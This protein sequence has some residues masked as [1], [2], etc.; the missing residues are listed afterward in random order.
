MSK[1]NCI[2][3]Q[4]QNLC[5]CLFYI[6]TVKRWHHT[7]STAIVNYISNTLSNL[8]LAHDQTTDVKSVHRQWFELATFEYLSHLLSHY[9][10]KPSA[11]WPRHCFMQVITALTWAHNL[12]K[13]GTTLVAQLLWVIYLTITL[14][15][16]C[17]SL[18]LYKYFVSKFILK[19]LYFLCSVFFFTVFCF[20]ILFQQS[21]YINNVIYNIYCIFHWFSFCQLDLQNWLWWVC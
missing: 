18:L 10:L 3:I 8:Q 2:Y 14:F 20:C 7:S 16:V 15:K 13:G 9:K 19:H 5:C 12:L 4:W 1:Y 21:K 17:I 6:I 11:R